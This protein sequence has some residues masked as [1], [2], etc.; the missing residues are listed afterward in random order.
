MSEDIIISIL[1]KIKSFKKIIHNVKVKKL[2][3]SNNAHVLFNHISKR[4]NSFTIIK[5]LY[6][7]FLHLVFFFFFLRN[8]YLMFIFFIYKYKTATLYGYKVTK[9]M[10]SF[11]SHGMSTLRC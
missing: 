7:Y 2:L 9:W 5:S 11:I 3:L 6:L 8:C 4:I 1:L 10:T